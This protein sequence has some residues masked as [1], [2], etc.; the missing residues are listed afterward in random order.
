MRSSLI[1]QAR[2]KFNDNVLVRDKKWRRHKNQEEGHVK[3]ETEPLQI[4]FCVSLI[5]SH[6]LFSTTL[7]MYFLCP[8]SG[9]N[10]SQRELIH[11]LGNRI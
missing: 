8:I 1:T 7:S 3:I 4:G 2:P 6:Q 11:F 9:T 5:C 10:F